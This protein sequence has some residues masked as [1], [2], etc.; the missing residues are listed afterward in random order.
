M[1]GVARIK[2]R[3]SILHRLKITCGQV[4]LLWL[5]YRPARAL[6]GCQ[7]KTPAWNDADDTSS[8]PQMRIACDRRTDDPAV[9]TGAS[10]VNHEPRHRLAS[11]EMLKRMLMANWAN[12]PELRDAPP[13]IGW[14]ARRQ[15]LQCPRGNAK[16]IRQHRDSDVDTDARLA[17]A[18][19]ERSAISFA[20]LLGTASE[21]RRRPRA[22]K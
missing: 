14:L 12:R 2:I 18:K 1:P 8:A 22:L 10:P 13:E 20:A 21:T 17:I 15:S 11:T 9:A 7:A 16:R 3:L 4:V 19:T 6:R 5:A